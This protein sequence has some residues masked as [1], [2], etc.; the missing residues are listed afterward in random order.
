MDESHC[1]DISL[2]APAMLPSSEDLQAWTSLGIQDWNLSLTSTEQGHPLNQGKSD[3]A[4]HFI[5]D[6]LL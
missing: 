5:A 3:G 1:S 6:A 4:H 2:K